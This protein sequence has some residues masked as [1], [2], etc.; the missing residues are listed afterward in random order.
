MWFGGG[1]GG[2]RGV[3]AGL[4]VRYFSRERAVNVRKIN[5]KVPYPEASSIAQSLYQVIKQN[6]PLSV[7]NAWIQAKVLTIAFSH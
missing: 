2:G 3:A 7:S 6:G 5:P 4:F 1:G